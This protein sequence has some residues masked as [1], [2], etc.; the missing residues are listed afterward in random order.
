MVYPSRFKDTLD[1]TTSVKDF[2]HGRKVEI[3]Y[4]DGMPTFRE[5]CRYEGFIPEV[6]QPGVPRSN[7]IIERT[8]QDVKYGTRALLAQ[9]GMP[10]CL[11]V[12][13]CTVLLYVG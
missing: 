10:A 2:V 12:F 13:C 4:T 1:V 6:S 5:V 3:T 9:A 8:N 7:S 11:W